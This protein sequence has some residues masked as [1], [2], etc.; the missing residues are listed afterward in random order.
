MLGGSQCIRASATTAGLGS[1]RLGTTVFACSPRLALRPAR[2][3]G[4]ATVG[5]PKGYSITCL[6]ALSVLNNP[7]MCLLSPCH[8]GENQ[9]SKELSNFVVNKQPTR[10]RCKP[11]SFFLHYVLVSSALAQQC[12]EIVESETRRAEVRGDLLSNRETGPT[13]LRITTAVS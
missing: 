13:T 12:P 1:W 11:R 10:G 8:R 2:R 5:C 4:S 9:G 3:R 7:V 6:T